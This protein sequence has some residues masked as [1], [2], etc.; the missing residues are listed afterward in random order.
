MS[1]QT[2]ETE[3]MKSILGEL[4]S[5]AD[6]ATALRMSPETLCRWGTQRIGPAPTR[7]G[8]KVYYRRDSVEQW[9]RAQEQSMP[10][11]RRSGGRR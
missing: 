1:V 2:V 10:N 4:I 3:V 5:R 8:R 9:L 7:I 6:L 11:P